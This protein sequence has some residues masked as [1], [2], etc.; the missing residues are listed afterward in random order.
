[1]MFNLISVLGGAPEWCFARVLQNGR[2]ITRADVVEGAEGIGPLAGDEIHAM[3]RMAG[4]ATAY[5]DSV[6]N[7]GR[8]PSRFGLEIFG[9]EGVV[10][11]FDTGHLPEMYWLPD[12]Q[13]SPGQTGKRWIPISSVGVG[14]PEPLK[15]GGLAGGNVLAVRDLL[16]AL[17]HG[18]EP[19]ANLREARVTMEMVVAI[20]ESQRQGRA[21][22]IPLDLRKNPLTLL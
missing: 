21:V 13:W 6:R 14:E 4:G 15:N 19:V 5:W 2:G 20:F 11:M 7:A 18:R 16:D 3:F 8:P 17:E 9:S 22:T 10:Q 12:P 1:H